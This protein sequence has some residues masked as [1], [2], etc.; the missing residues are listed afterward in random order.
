M[1]E[2]EEK[3]A[4]LEG[5]ALFF[6]GVAHRCKQQNDWLK[7]RVKTLT[8]LCEG[9]QVSPMPDEDVQLKLANLREDMSEL[10]VM[11]TKS[12][13]LLDQ[14]CQLNMEMLRKARDLTDAEIF[15]N[16]NENE[17]EDEDTQMS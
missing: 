13:I 10:V 14:M 12:E 6:Q 11:Q 1:I 7:A 9:K 15:E 17:N 3:I 16:E 4:E 2:K 8:A 5:Q